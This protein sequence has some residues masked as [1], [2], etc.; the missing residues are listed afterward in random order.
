MANNTFDVTG[1]TDLIDAIKSGDAYINVHSAAYP[2]GEIRGQILSSGNEAPAEATSL[3]PSLVNVAGDA[4]STAFSV[5]WL[6]VGD[7]DGDTINYLLQMSLDANFTMVA[8]LTNFGQT[9]GIAYTV[10]E[11]AALFDYLTDSDPNSDGTTAVFYHRVITTD[12]SLWT[13]GP[14]S[15]TSLR[16]GAITDTESSSELPTEFALKGN[17]PNPFNPSTN[18]RFD[19]PQSADV[20]VVVVDLLGRQVLSV[21]SAAFEGGSGRTIQ[22]DASALSSGIY[23]YQIIARSQG[24]VD[25]ATGTMTLIK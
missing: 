15:S 10:E 12:G 23:M 7:P 14:S 11:A 5:S 13:A 25:V 21:P 18:I 4:S 3:A 24:G 19:L 16:R 1:M 22:I 6:P 17:Y 20:S 8:D 9:N 2:G